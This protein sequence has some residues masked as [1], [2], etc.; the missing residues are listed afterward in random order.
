MKLTIQIKNN[1]TSVNIFQGKK[2]VNQIVLEEINHLSDQLL[3]MIDQLL[4]K[5]KVTLADIQKIDSDLDIPE[6]FTSSRI[7]KA[8]VNGLRVK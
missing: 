4:Q 1:I 7:V 5:N 8:V 3:P 6:T 2:L